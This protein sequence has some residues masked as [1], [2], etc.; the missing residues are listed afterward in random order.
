MWK[1]R[2]HEAAIAL[3]K[4]SL[5]Q[6]RL[7]H[8]Y[9]VTGPE[10]IG[11]ATLA[12]ELAM[13]LNCTTWQGEALPTLFGEPDV[14]GTEPG[15]CY[16]CASCLK[17]LAGSHPDILAVE[18]WTTEHG[19]M[20][21]QVRAIQYGSGLLPFEG[22][23]KVYLLLNAEDMTG[24]AQNTLLKTLEEPASTVCLILTAATPRALLPTVVSRCQHLQLRAP[25]AQAIAEALVEMR[26]VEP[27]RARQLAAFAAG[28][29]GWAL[30]A[31]GDPALLEQRQAALDGLA[32]ALRGGTATRFRLAETLAA[33]DP[34]AVDDVL[35]LWLSWLR[36]LLLAIEGLPDR[37]VN[38]DQ[39]DHVRTAASQLQ[40][41]DVQG[42]IRAVQAARSQV[43][44][45]VNTRMALEVLL[46]RLPS[47]SAVRT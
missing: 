12:R 39:L 31:A 14:A 13:T 9:L 41:R 18:E 42:A 33:S 5:S 20:T 36:D 46:L 47:L 30:D 45:A 7:S 21:D 15:P 40:G 29:I 16:H 34:K 27:E 35:E 11:K 2:G 28:R 6:D 43:A 24:A 26:E 32:A 23:R 3:L 1:T 10:R 22:H 25:A 44:G 38:R 37:V 19:A 17:A 4:R 8:A